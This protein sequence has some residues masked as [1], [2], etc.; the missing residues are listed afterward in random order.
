[1]HA[2]EFGL[3]KKELF[4]LVATMAKTAR[5]LSS[6]IEVAPDLLIS[7]LRTSISPELETITE[8]ETEECEEEDL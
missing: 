7:P 8:E 2:L 1:M 3:R 4:I 5:C 6:W